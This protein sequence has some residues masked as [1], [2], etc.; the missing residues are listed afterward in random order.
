MRHRDNVNSLLSLIV[1]SLMSFKISMVRTRAHEYVFLTFAIVQILPLNLNYFSDA[2]WSRVSKGN[3]ENVIRRL[4]P[5]T[6]IA[7]CFFDLL[8]LRT[9]TFHVLLRRCCVTDTRRNRVGYPFLRDK[10]MYLWKWF[11]CRSPHW[12]IGP[13]FV[14]FFLVY[15]LTVRLISLQSIRT[16]VDRFSNFFCNCV[17]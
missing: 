14:L 15:E 4:R 1:K 11:Y 10:F 13:L 8:P 16:P 12:L 17:K 6:K 3:T 9:S 2:L 7:Q 5:G